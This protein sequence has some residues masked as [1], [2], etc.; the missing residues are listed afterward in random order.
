MTT[1]DKEEGRIRYLGEKP[2]DFGEDGNLKAA[3]IPN[4]IVWPIAIMCLP[5]IIMWE[6]FMRIFKKF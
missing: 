2:E 5:L 4:W 3:A 6:I 1:Y